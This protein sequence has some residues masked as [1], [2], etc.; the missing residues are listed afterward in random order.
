M[1]TR[2]A[3]LLFLFDL[4][5]QNDAL[6]LAGLHLAVQGLT[7]DGHG[8]EG[9]AAH[10][11]HPVDAELAVRRSLAVLDLKLAF[12]ILQDDFAALDVAGR[13]Q[14]DLD[15]VAPGRIEPE[16]VVERRHPVDFGC[17]NF[18][19]IGDEPDR[20]RRQ[21]GQ[22]I[23]NELQHGDQPAALAPHPLQMQRQAS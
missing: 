5:F 17:G 18:Q 8:R 16:L 12:E 4:D 20:R 21:I 9:A 22:G 15:R 11:G 23:L 1:R 14:T 3:L 19:V 13:P 7:D 2:F 10:A 6:H